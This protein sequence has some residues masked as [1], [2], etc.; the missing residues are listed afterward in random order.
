MPTLAIKSTV[1]LQTAQ[2]FHSS[3]LI[4]M[5]GF[6]STLLYLKQFI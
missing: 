2:N 6:F 5:Q 4:S 1:H 3:F